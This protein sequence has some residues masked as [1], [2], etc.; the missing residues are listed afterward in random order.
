M[1]NMAVGIALELVKTTT[2][3]HTVI[4]QEEALQTLGTRHKHVRK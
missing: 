3:P 1:C 2:K 4:R